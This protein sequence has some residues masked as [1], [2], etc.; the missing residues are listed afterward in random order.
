MN[1]TPSCDFS[2][3]TSRPLWGSTVPNLHCQ[4]ALNDVR[5]L[6]KS[7]P[8][9][10][11]VH[12]DTCGPGISPPHRSAISLCRVLCQLRRPLPP[13]R[14]MSFPGISAVRIPR[15]IKDQAERKHGLEAEPKPFRSP[16]MPAA[17]GNCRGVEPAEV[18]RWVCGGVAACAEATYCEQLEHTSIGKGLCIGCQPKQG[19]ARGGGRPQQAWKFDNVSFEH[20]RARIGFGRSLLRLRSS[21]TPIF[22]DPNRSGGPTLDLG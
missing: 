13:A 6:V 17:S 3:S 8:S 19:Y 5:S 1:T 20:G 21:Q 9:S 11:C 7:A 16:L 22:E 18:E 15:R 4:R 10:Y 12:H 2:W 14:N